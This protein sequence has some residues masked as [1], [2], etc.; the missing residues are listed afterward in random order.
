M[1]R[2]PIDGWAEV[3]VVNALEAEVLR[4]ALETAGIPVIQRREA[5][6]QVVGITV[7]TLGDVVLF[8]PGDR[9]SEARQL[10]ETS[11]PID[12]PEGD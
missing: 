11:K 5:Y 10:L 6:G 9:L 1:K 8:V 7:G 12:F 2:P 3:V 4:A